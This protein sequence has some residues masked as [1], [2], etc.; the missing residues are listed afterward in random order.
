MALSDMENLLFITKSIYPEVAKRYHTSAKNVERNIRTVVGVAWDS[1]P[2]LLIRL[3]N[4]DLHEKPTSTEFIAIL[5]TSILCS[6][7]KE[8]YL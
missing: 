6:Q 5:A 7:L 2:E 1:N 4:R 8:E 3:A